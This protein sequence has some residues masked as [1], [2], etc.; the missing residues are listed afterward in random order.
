L[1]ELGSS[2]DGKKVLYLPPGSTTVRCV[3][4]NELGAATDT[5]AEIRLSTDNSI[6]QP[7]SLFVSIV[8]FFTL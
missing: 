5:L 2:V 6:V 1:T 8:T 4:R 3:A 7:G